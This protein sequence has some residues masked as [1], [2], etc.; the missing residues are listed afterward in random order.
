MVVLGDLNG[1]AMGMRRSEDWERKVVV[2]CLWDEFLGGV[3]G[4]RESTGV[5]VY[6]GWRDWTECKVGWKW[7][8]LVEA[9]ATRR[10]ECIAEG[11]VRKEDEILAGL[12]AGIGVGISD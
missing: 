12:A 6:S 9:R 11:H 3:H 7:A 10:T 1:G 2:L 5:E 8:G 4:M